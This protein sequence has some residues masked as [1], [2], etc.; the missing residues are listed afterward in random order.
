MPNLR[1]KADDGSDFPDWDSKTLGELGSFQKGA[2]LSKADI[3]DQGTPLILYG[4]L[5]TTYSEVT[6]T[7]ARKTEKSSDPKFLSQSGDVLIPTSGETAVDISRATCVMQ[8]GVILAGD[9]LIYRPTEGLDGRIL[10][11]IVNYQVKAAISR[12]AQ[13]GQVVHIKESDIS[14]IKAMFPVDPTEQRKIADCLYAIDDV[15]AKAKAE[16][17]VWELRKKGVVQRLF[18]QEVR[19]KADDGSIFPAWKTLSFSKVFSRV[20]NNSLSWAKLIRESDSST[21]HP[22]N[23]HYGDIHTRFGEVL[24]LAKDQ[25]PVIKDDV[26]CS[27]LQPLQE[28]DVVFADAAED[29]TVGKAIEVYNLGANVLYAGLH[30]IAC[31]PKITFAP[32]YLGYYLNAASFHDQLRP[33]MQRT[34]VTSISKT[35]IALTYVSVPSPQEQRKIAD[36]LYAIDEV[37]AKAKA[38]LELWREL[39]RGLLQQLFV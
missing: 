28:G 30:T 35:N 37:I 10:S 11:C 3:S 29:D 22:K 17:E 2:P 13:G 32:K 5:Y 7:V 25:V 9:L 14:K 1:F 38:E 4:E 34:K 23:I 39:K 33:Y 8:D 18:S 16:I 27:R 15:I 12:V 19:F 26:D 31:R 21:H 24:D 20:T 36:C 6:Y